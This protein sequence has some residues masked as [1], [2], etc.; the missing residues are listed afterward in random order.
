MSPS[1]SQLA[2]HRWA[3][4]RRLLGLIFSVYFCTSTIKTACRVC[5]ANGCGSLITNL[6]FWA[7]AVHCLYFLSQIEL[8]YVSHATVREFHCFLHSLS[9]GLSFYVAVGVSVLFMYN[10][11]FTQRHADAEHLPVA[12]VWFFSIMAHYVPPLLHLAG[13]TAFD[14]FFCT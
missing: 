1:V 12:T 2:K 5:D 6:T 7:W 3:A 11:S 4:V 14:L 8:S 10:S 13:A 9:L